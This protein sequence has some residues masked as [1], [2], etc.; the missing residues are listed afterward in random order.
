MPDAWEALFGIDDPDGDAD[1]DGATNIQE[2][3]AGTNPTN[4]LSWLRITQINKGES[5]VLVVWSAIGGTRYRI[6]YSDGDGQSGFSG[7]FTALPRP[8]TEEM[9]PDPAGS[10]G[11]MSFFDDFTLTGGTPPRDM[12]YYRIQVVTE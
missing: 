8:V 4:A 5:G 10:P 11:T 2:Y 7:L 1:G 9:D 3:R 6:L 12:R